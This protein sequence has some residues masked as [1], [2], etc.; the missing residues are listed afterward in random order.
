MIMPF[1]KTF[2]GS[3][4]GSGVSVYLRPFFSEVLIRMCYKWV[5]SVFSHMYSTFSQKKR[6]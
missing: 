6:F 4:K 3:N 2:S 1:L 5:E